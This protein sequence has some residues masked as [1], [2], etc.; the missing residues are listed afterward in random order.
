M[1]FKESGIEYN[2]YI[3]TTEQRHKESVLHFW[4]V[5]NSHKVIS[6]GSHTGY[7]STN[8]ETFVMEKDL[9]KEGDQFKT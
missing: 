4:N 2:D 9:I 1:L 8:D 7:Y 5:L 6:L 3:R